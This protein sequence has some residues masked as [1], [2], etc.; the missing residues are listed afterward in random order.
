MVCGMKNIYFNAAS[1]V[2]AVNNPSEAYDYVI[3]LLSP[4]K[5]KLSLGLAHRG[6]FFVSRVGAGRS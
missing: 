3:K 4:L 6:R 5:S 1:V 2:L